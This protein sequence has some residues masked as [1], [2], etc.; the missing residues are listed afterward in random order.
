VR[1]PEPKTPPPEESHRLQA[2]RPPPCNHLTLASGCF[3]QA[4]L[5]T[6]RPRLGHQLRDDS[7]ERFDAFS[8]G[9]ETIEVRPRA[10]RAM[11]ELGI[12]AKPTSR[13]PPPSPNRAAK[14]PAQ[15]ASLRRGGRSPR[16]RSRLCG[17][18]AGYITQ[19]RRDERTV[20][21]PHWAVTGPPTATRIGWSSHGPISPCASTTQLREGAEPRR[22]FPPSIAFA[23]LSYVP[24]GRR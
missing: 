13:H 19:D 16:W 14:L 11:A 6:T 5:S 12:D 24:V 3:Q 20:V 15:V 10:I 7:S 8:A 4:H 1:T 22:S 9:T 21:E 18:P 17:D 2:C 23:V